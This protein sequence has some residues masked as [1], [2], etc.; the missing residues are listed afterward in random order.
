MA[1]K[2][3]FGGVCVDA[4]GTIF[5]RTTTS[6]SGVMNQPLLV[7]P[8]FEEISSRDLDFIEDYVAALSVYSILEGLGE[9]DEELTMLVQSLTNKYIYLL[10]PLPY[11]SDIIEW[12]GKIKPA[13][14][15]KIFTVFGEDEIYELLGKVI[16]Y[17]ELFD[18]NS[19]DN[20]SVRDLCESVEGF[21][22]AAGVKPPVWGDELRE[23]GYRCITAMGVLLSKIIFG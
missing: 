15:E 4:S 2:I 1:L 12:A 11:Y 9:V 16:I 5:T 18:Q 14:L 17:K 6:I 19:I 23:K 20:L 10:H 8:V 7:E 3:G 21:M 13:S 22:E